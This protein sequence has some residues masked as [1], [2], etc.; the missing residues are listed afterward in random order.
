M[1][2]DSGCR[3]AVRA[4]RPRRVVPAFAVAL[5][6]TAAGALVAVQIASA[7]LGHPALPPAEIERAA[8]LLRA[9]RWSDP[10]ALAASVAVALAGSL[11]VLASA[12]PGR[13]R[14]VALSGDDPRFIAGVTRSGL[15]AALRAAVLAVPGITDARVRLRGRLRPRAVVRAVTRF[16]NPSSL[17]DQVADATRARIAG[18]GPVRVPRVAVR[19]RC[20]ED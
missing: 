18:I 8:R 3:A 11:L 4:F 16:R 10:A 20:P 12:L 17:H 14:T 13:G 9:T 19:I 2:M 7:R 6:V 5:P 15:C 1:T